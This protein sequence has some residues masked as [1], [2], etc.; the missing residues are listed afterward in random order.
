MKIDRLLFLAAS[1]SMAATVVACGTGDSK[2]SLVEDAG[3][4]TKESP[5]TVME[6]CAED[7]G[8][9][10]GI[11]DSAPPAPSDA[12]ADSGDASADGEAG[13]VVPTGDI[14]EICAPFTCEIGEW[15]CR[16]AVGGGLSANVSSALYGCAQTVCV[17]DKSWSELQAIGLACAATALAAEAP[18][19]HVNALCSGL[20]GCTPQAGELS[21]DRCEVLYSGLTYSGTS[22]L[23]NRQLTCGETE[24][25][26][27][28]ETL[29]ELA[30]HP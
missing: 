15:S 10:G 13:V 12:G 17:A 8:D 5:A 26:F 20:V 19:A 21:L 2:T 9:G 25:N 11:F 22:T 28:R 16:A 23:Q 4:A 30:Y 7:G 27:V 24:V 18:S 29:F 14:E 6:P 1:A 3:S